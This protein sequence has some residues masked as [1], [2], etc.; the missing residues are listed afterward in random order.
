MRA[1]Q[2]SLYLWRALSQLSLFLL[3]AVFNAVIIAAAFLS[4]Y[5]DVVT[6]RANEASK[7]WATVGA[8]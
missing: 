1:L 7:Q 3:D 5:G 4:L 8:A 6:L 2:G